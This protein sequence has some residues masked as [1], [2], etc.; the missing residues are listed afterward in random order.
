M[1]GALLHTAN[2]CG[3]PGI[4]EEV[5]HTTTTRGSGHKAPAPSLSRGTAPEDLSS[6]EPTAK[7]NNTPNPQP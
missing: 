5:K 1:I 6:K 2:C 7:W 4:D 3:G